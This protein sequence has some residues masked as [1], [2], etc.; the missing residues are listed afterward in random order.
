MTH[1]RL[2]DAV[3]ARRRRAGIMYN[4][5]PRRYGAKVS[6]RPSQGRNPGSTPG[7]ATIRSVTFQMC[8]HANVELARGGR[9]ACEAHSQI[10]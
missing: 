9:R 6:T 7:T 5:C 4:V 10:R 8:V 2:A 1:R 3:I